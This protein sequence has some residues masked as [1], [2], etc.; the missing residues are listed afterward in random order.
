LDLE[1]TQNRD[2]IEEMVKTQG[3]TLRSQSA[4]LKNLRRSRIISG[5]GWRGR[6]CDLVKG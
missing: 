6:L 4:V 5:P 1:K 2:V 3:R